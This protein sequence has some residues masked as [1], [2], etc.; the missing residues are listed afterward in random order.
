ML[1]ISILIVFAILYR[2]GE[3]SSLQYFSPQWWG[4]L[5]LIGWAYGMTGL[6]LIVMR[7]S[8]YGVF[9]AWL[10]FALLSMLYHEGGTTGA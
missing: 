6:L 1:A 5:G 7:N 9:G 3:D 8:F 2:G 4:I 10:F